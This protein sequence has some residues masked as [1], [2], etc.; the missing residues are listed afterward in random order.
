MRIITL[1]FFTF[2]F[3]VNSF[4]FDYKKAYAGELLDQIRETHK[5]ILCAGP[6]AWPYTS[7]TNYPRGFDIEIMERITANE[8][9]Y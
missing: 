9:F 1:L 2:I 5:L 7:S 4:N 6:Y 8:D 3:T